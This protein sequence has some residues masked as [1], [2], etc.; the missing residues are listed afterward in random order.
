MTKLYSP[1][2][3]LGYF[4]GCESEAMYHIYSPEKHKVYRISIAR[5]E[6]G[7]GLDDPHNTPCLEDRVPTPELEAP[8]YLPS[9]GEE[10]TS[11]DEDNKRDDGSGIRS[12]PEE[13]RSLSESGLS[14]ADTI[15]QLQPELDNADGE[16]ESD[17]ETGPAI[18]S[19][20]F[21]QPRCAGM[22]KRKFPE[23][24]MVVLK[25]SRQATHD[26]GFVGQNDSSS[27]T[28]DENN[29]SWYYSDNGKVSQTYWDFVAKYGIR[30][31]KQYL[32]DKDK[33]NYC[34]RYGRICDMQNGIPCS[35]YKTVKT[36][37]GAQTKETKR[38]V[39]PE[40]RN[41]AK[42]IMGPKQEQPC[43]RCFQGALNC[44][45]IIPLSGETCPA[46]GI[47]AKIVPGTY[48]LAVMP[49]VGHVSPDERI[50]DSNTI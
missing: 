27:E 19:K 50:R 2:S 3:W 41:R 4:V 20:Y 21:D 40:N 26:L 24:A 46:P 49:S 1:R 23:G 10:K 39:L 43:K 14:I 44:Y 5:V 22:A 33:C 6:D 18:T 28:P 45:S 29:D 13:A 15:H 30:M 9:E 8:D 17:T 7:E 35:L 34:F 31:K 48:R 38:L 36:K 12:F 47:T 42:P 37:Y 16:D 11:D 25:K 32:P